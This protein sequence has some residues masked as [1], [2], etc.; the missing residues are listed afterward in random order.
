VSL[1]CGGPVSRHSYET[2]DA[3]GTFSQY[4]RAP[5]VCMARYRDADVIIDA[6][7]GL[8]YFSPLWR[9]RP[10]V[11]LVHHVHTD[12]WRSRFPAPMADACA[13][14]ERAVMPAVYR[15]RPFVAISQS[16]SEALEAIGVRQ[17]Q[18]SLIESG[19][20][21]PKGRLPEKSQ[22]PLFLSLNRVVPHKRI[23]LL[24]DA[25]RVAGP[26]IG[27]K[28][29]IA[30]D[31]PALS[32]V[33]RAAASVPGVEVAGRISEEAKRDLLGRS[34]AVL[35]ASHHEGWGMSITEAA[36]FGTPSIALDA[37]G[38][39]DAIVDGVTGILV[40]ES[41]EGAL[42]EMLARA[43]V[44]FAKDGGR[45]EVL[46]ASARLRAEELSW[47]RSVDRWEVLLQRIIEAGVC[48]VAL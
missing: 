35:S 15:R 41:A 36:S 13:W 20:D 18:I 21:I 14:I 47:E 17:E 48:P 46:G 3:G 33:R 5:A 19:V 7:N 43:M 23:G 32:G 1:V 22:E 30:G 4:V 45:R 29:V 11:C 39:R 38:I 34:W 2:V 31:G 25:W 44:E 37:P 42:P 27:G 40:R 24:V 10:S 9:R 6:E 12:Q 26:K 16:T 8:P 28:L